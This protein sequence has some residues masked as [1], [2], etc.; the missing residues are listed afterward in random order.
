MID[1]FIL[2]Y[3]SHDRRKNYPSE[4]LAVRKITSKHL[5]VKSDAQ[6]SIW[7]SLFLKNLLMKKALH[8]KKKLGRNF[9]LSCLKERYE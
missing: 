1:Q 2:N 6:I 8:S 4:E 9:F 3:G 5:F 7:R